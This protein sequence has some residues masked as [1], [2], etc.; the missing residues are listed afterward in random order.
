MGNRWRKKSN[1]MQARNSRRQQPDDIWCHR[2]RKRRIPYW[3]GHE[4]EIERTRF[5]KIHSET[6]QALPGRKP[7]P[8]LEICPQ[9]KR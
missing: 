5:Q 3:A 1:A 6:D 8:R 2:E 4:A 9:G 7:R